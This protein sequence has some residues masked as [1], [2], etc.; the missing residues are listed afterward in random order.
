[1]IG[2]RLDCP[3]RID[4]DL[5]AMLEHLHGSTDADRRQE[6]DDKSGDGAAQQWFGGQESPIGGFGDRLR[7]PLDR[8]GT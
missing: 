8:I 2:E 6:G 4:D 1:M 3:G 5:P 7:Q